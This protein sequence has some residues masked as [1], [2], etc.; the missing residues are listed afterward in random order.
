MSPRPYRMEGPA[1][2]PQL[3]G[4][5]TA[6]KWLVCSFYMQAMPCHLHYLISK[7]QKVHLDQSVYFILIILTPEELS[8]E[9]SVHLYLLDFSDPQDTAVMKSTVFT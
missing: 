9:N 3:H 1:V 5:L 7:C 8:F 2:E 6:R 4:I